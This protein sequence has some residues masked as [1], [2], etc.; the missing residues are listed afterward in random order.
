VTFCFCLAGFFCAGFYNN[1]LFIQT[2]PKNLS[3]Y[4]SFSR[5]VEPGCYMQPIKFDKVESVPF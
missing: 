1:D 5:F 2:N 3:D 4:L